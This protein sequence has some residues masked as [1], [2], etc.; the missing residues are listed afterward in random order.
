[1]HLCRVRMHPRNSFVASR[2]ARI[3]RSVSRQAV[4]EESRG[5]LTLVILEGANGVGKS[6]YA[7][8]LEIA[9]N[10][11]TLR[12]FRPN[13]D[14]H[15][16]GTSDLEA[17]LRAARV[18]V[19]SHI[20]DFY[21]ADL[22]SK[23]EPKTKA[24][25]VF[26]RSLPSALVYSGWP[27][28]LYVTAAPR[29]SMIDFWES[30]LEP[31]Q[32]RLYVWLD[33]SADTCEGRQMTRSEARETRTSRPS[34]AVLQREFDQIFNQIKMPKLYIDTSLDDVNDGLDAVLRMTWANR[35]RSD[36]ERPKP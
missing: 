24:N 2:V 29:T 10:A 14:F 12:P 25:F 17:K 4:Q 16:R 1:M 22:L 18:P 23:I 32:N 8:R 19:N 15:F 36:S 33:G 30:I 28:A 27:S 31:I 9:M 7:K 20:E 11:L 26:D 3:R 35:P 13:S 5:P 34:F 6:T 21:A